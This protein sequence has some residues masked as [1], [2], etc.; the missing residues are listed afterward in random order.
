MTHQKNEIQR[1]TVSKGT[2]EQVSKTQMGWGLY[3][4]AFVE[5]IKKDEI[6]EKQEKSRILNIPCAILQK[7][8]FL[9]C[10]Y[11]LCIKLLSSA[12]NKRWSAI[13]KFLCPTV[14]WR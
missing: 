10:S 7:P 12:S 3:D 5:G 14:Q 8:I 9:T 2:E 13:T 11:F 4:E 6:V 1:K